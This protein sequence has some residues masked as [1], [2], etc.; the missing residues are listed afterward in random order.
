MLW[1]KVPKS[2]YF[3]RGAV[4]EALKELEGLKR[5]LLVTDSYLFR[6]GHA[7]STIDLLKQHGLEVEVFSQVEADPTLAQVRKGVEV[8]VAFQPDVIVAFGGGSPMDA[9][10]ILWVMY[11]HPEVQFEDLAMRF[12]DIR[13]R[14]YRFP[15]MGIKAQFVAIPTTSGTGSEVTPFAV[16]TDETTGYKYPIADYELMPHMAIIDANFV[17]NLPKSITAAGGLDAITHSI[18]AYVSVLASEF[19]DGQ[20]LQALRLLKQYLPAAYEEGANNPT[21]RERVH[22]AATIAGI[23]FANAFLGVCH[24]LAHK[25]GAAFHLPHG[26]ANALL[27]SNVIRYNANDNP[28]K[29]AAFSQYDRP[30]AKCRYAEIAAHLGLPGETSDEKVESLIAWFDTFKHQLAVPDSIRDMGIPEADFLAKVDAIALDAFD[31]QC[32]GAN[33]RYPLI[34]ELKAILLDS[35]YGHPFVELYARHPAME[36]SLAVSMN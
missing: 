33:P 15:K 12:M 4:V 13:K 17:M 29:L 36:T 30:K 7:D 20:A 16:V 8:A 6:N 1:F 21:A 10:K 27:L 28:T 24:S 23:A 2:V 3:R 9:A 26:I 25:L 14:I 32:T 31:D 19:T 34:D 22:S 5:A 18:E 35:Y 11:E